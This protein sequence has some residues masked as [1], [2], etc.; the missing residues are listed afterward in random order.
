MRWLF[1]AVLFFLFFVVVVLCVCFG[2]T[3]QPVCSGIGRCLCLVSSRL[4]EECWR[5][6]HS[7]LEQLRLMTCQPTYTEENVAVM[8]DQ[9]GL[10]H[11]RISLP[12]YVTLK[13]QYS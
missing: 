1:F 9:R 5:N 6:D 8:E 7:S 10:S 4:V 13:R 12:C 11:P 2:H 3:G